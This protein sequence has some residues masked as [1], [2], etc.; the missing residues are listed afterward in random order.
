MTENFWV[1]NDTQ[2]IRAAQLY[3]HIAPFPRGGVKHNDVIVA[4][5][6]E[7]ILQPQKPLRMHALLNCDDPP[8]LAMAGAGDC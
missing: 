2:P 6:C 8:K 7:G 1:Q 4:D 5:A 3:L